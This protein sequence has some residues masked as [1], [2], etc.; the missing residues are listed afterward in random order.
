MAII[1]LIAHTDIHCIYVI[2]LYFNACYKQSFVIF[3]FYH[4]ASSLTYTVYRYWKVNRN[5]LYYM[6]RPSKIDYI[7][8]YHPIYKEE[9]P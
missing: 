4:K 5:D 3:K 2:K 7:L 8:V 6:I 1:L 9:S